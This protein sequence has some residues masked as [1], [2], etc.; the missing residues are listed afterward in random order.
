MALFLAMDLAFLGANLLKLTDGGWLPILVGGCLFLLMT[1]WRSGRA[2]VAARIAEGSLPL[3]SFLR[4]VREKPPLRVPG[5]AVYLTS[6]A[7]LTPQALL[8]NLKHNKVLHERLIFLTVQNVAEPRVPVAERFVFEEPLPNVLR[9]RAR[10]GFMQQP[11]VPRAL[12]QCRQFGLQLEP[13]QTS[14]FIGREV[15][16]PTRGR[17]MWIWRER[18]FAFMVKNA[19]S[20]H[21]F[22]RIPNDRVIELGTQVPI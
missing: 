10:Y 14:F 2:L 12:A 5:T 17:G 18:L 6:D 3:T 22:F 8:H 20:A 1:T 4:R 11:N 19:T 9:I 21:E 7:E 13:M 15:P 16:L